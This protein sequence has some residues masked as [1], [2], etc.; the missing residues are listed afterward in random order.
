MVDKNLP[1][2]IKIT[3]EKKG[4]IVIPSLQLSTME[5]ALS[6]H[7][8]IQLCKIS[9][10]LVVVEP[11]TFEYYLGQLSP[12]GIKVIKGTTRVAAGYQKD[13]PYNLAT[14]GNIAI[15]H[16]KYTDKAILENMECNRIQVKQG[17]GKCNTLFAEDAIITSDF[18]IYA[19]ID[20]RKLLIS[21]GNIQ[22]EGYEYGFIGGASGYFGK[23][24]FIGNLHSHPD[25]DKIDKFL[26]ECNIEY[27]SLGLGILQD[28]GSLIFF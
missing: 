11:S 25:F 8:D 26:I 14:N 9:E 15:H 27:E 6:T 23:L 18:G 13:V 3:L 28:Y 22:L 4:F 19:K 17:Y 24:Y 1:E 16:F 10:K 2:N 21:P 20:G 12:Y 7:P 5:G